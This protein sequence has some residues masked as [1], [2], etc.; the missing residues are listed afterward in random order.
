MLA[1]LERAEAELA[2]GA[3]HLD[4]M[5][6]LA[7]FASALHELVPE[8]LSRLAAVAPDLTVLVIEAEPDQALP[9]LTRHELDL[10]IA[11]EYDLVAGSVGCR[12][13]FGASF[14]DPMLVVGLPGRRGLAPVVLDQL[15]EQRW[16]LPPEDTYCGQL[17]RRACEAAGFRS[18]PA[19]TSQDFGALAAMAATGLGVALVPQFALTPEARRSARPLA[20]GLAATLTALR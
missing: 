19:A 17:V 18:E 13:A 12:A 14:I 5:L 6:R 20:P 1:A 15:A 4:G 11:F 9:A 3:E 8:A 7:A 10:V 2:I 16:L